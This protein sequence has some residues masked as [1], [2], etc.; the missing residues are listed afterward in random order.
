MPRTNSQLAR[1]LVNQQ[2]WGRINSCKTTAPNVWHADCAGHGGLVA[3]L[4]AVPD[5]LTRDALRALGVVWTVWQAPGLK[6]YWDR[7]GSTWYG[8]QISDRPGAT[9]TEWVVGEEDCAW[10]LVVAAIPAAVA[11][12]TNP[13]DGLDSAV[14]MIDTYWDDTP[15]VTDGV[16]RWS[17]RSILIDRL[18]ELRAAS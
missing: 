2:G 16:A 11:A 10:A 18:T 5:D 12:L 7:P 1:S 8:D 6:P 9:S 17:A 15:T 14:Q 13:T 4:A 3:P